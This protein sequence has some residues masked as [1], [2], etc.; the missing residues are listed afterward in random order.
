[1]PSNTQLLSTGNRPD[2][3]YEEIYARAKEDGP[4]RGFNI[5]EIQFSGFHSQGDGASWTGTLIC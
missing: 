2:D 3:W 1:M 4:E 5:D